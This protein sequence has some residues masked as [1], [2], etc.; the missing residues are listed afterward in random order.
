LK[1]LL[2]L[3]LLPLLV[4]AQRKPVSTKMVNRPGDITAI[5][6]SRGAYQ[7]LLTD[8]AT[9]VRY[10]IVNFPDSL[11]QQAL[12]TPK[13]MSVICSGTLLPGSTALQTIG[14]NDVPVATKTKLRHLQLTAIRRN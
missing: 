11:L 8:R 12:D 10:V 5:V 13:P 3:A 9:K 2:F 1:T 14:T 6:I 4:L 7:F